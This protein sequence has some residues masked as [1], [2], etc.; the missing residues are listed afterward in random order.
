MSTTPQLFMF[1]LGGSAGRSNI[2][3]HDVQFVACQR[4]EDAI[5]ALKAAWFG[6]PDKVHIDGYQR[7]NWAD[8]H[9]IAL[10]REPAAAQPRLYFVNVGGYLPEQL[11]EAHA[12]GLFV[13]PDAETAKAKAKATLL[14]GHVQHHKDNLLSVDDCLLLAQVDGWHIHLQPQPGGSALPPQMQ[15]YHPI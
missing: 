10:S 8:G 12:F 9:A 3:V 14:A 7:L 4:M 1:Y 5:P 15:G 13:A 2:E 11:A 6:D